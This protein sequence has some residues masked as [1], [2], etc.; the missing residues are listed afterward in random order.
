MSFRK[1]LLPPHLKP[2]LIHLKLLLPHLD[3]SVFVLFFLETQA[4]DLA[5]SASGYY[6]VERFEDDGGD[7]AGDK[8]VDLE[9][10]SEVDGL[11]EQDLAVRSSKDDVS[12]VIRAVFR[13]CDLALSFT[14]EIGE[15]LI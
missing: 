8:C 14:Q 2:N 10:E 5:V 4:L 15:V 11:K 1:Q 13:C 3:I 9:N 7:G 12:V 6:E